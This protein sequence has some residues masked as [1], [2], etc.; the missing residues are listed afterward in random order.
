LIG[1]RLFYIYLVKKNNNKN[2][3]PGNNIRTI[4]NIEGL[5]S[6]TEL[7]LRRNAI[8]ACRLAEPPRSLQKLFLSNNLVRSF[9]DIGPVTA[10]DTIIE[11]TLDG[12][13]ATAVRGYRDIAAAR[14][15]QL[16]HLDL[17]RVEHELVVPGGFL[18]EPQVVAAR[19]AG[20]RGLINDFGGGAGDGVGDSGTDAPGSDEDEDHETDEEGILGAI[21]RGDLAVRRSRTID[22]RTADKTRRPAS[23]YRGGSGRSDSSDCS[24]GAG[25]G[26]GGG[27][28]EHASGSGSGARGGSRDPAASGGKAITVPR[29]M[30]PKTAVAPS[31]APPKARPRTAAP[32]TRDPAGAAA[33]ESH[34]SGAAE[35]STPAVP[36]TISVPAMGSSVPSATMASEARQVSD[37]VRGSYAVSARSASMILLDA[38]GLAALPP[39][40]ETNGGGGVASESAT[41]GSRADR[42]GRS[43]PGGSSK[44][45]VEYD[46]LSDTLAVFGFPTDGIDK[47]P[48]A[49]GLMLRFVPPHRLSQLISR[50]AVRQGQ[51]WSDFCVFFY[52]FCLLATQ[53]SKRKL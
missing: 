19:A 29:R 33:A 22:A 51:G 1:N 16:V 46:H 20:H 3:C 14:M 5:V 25:G 50:L 42:G 4:E 11:L 34:A 8:S 12:N 7:N 38:E 15:P 32:R 44:A 39:S 43:G 17:K 45:H 48:P 30:R 47:H 23:G 18:G 28:D 35:R 2:P 41:G 53:S 52:G 6:L 24:G 31:T 49:T 26:G 37:A 36:G 21:D 27:S 9:D 40:A 13:P 10:G